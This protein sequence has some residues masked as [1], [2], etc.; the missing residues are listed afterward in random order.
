[1][2]YLKLTPDLLDGIIKTSVNDGLIED[3]KGVFSL[4]EQGQ[5][6]LE[7]ANELL[8]SRRREV[9]FFINEKT[10]LIISLLCLVFLSFL[11]ILMGL[12]SGSDALFNEGMENFTD[13]IKIFIIYLSMKFQ[14]DRL[15]SIIIMMFMLLTGILLMITSILSLIS[16]EIV[17]PD[18]YTFIIVSISIGLNYFLMHYKKIVGKLSANFSLLTDAKD[19]INNIRLST[20]VLIGLLFS[21]G[22]IYYIDSI[23]GTFISAIIIYDGVITL[24][25][26]ILAGEDIKIDA[27]KLKIDEKFD[28][29]ISYWILKTLHDKPLSKENLNDRF[30]QALDKG[31]KYYD[32]FAIIE[33]YDIQK[34]GIKKILE[35]MEREG[36]FIQKDHKIRLTNKGITQYYRARAIEF[37]EAAKEYENFGKEFLDRPIDTGTVS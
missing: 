3:K 10:I 16:N 25:E 23:I 15:G 1:M 5:D 33:F 35:E 34:T 9:K 18:L 8:L 27:F 12:N 22:N 19:N 26:L 24:R 4:T 7:K 11:K 36:L 2:S 31:Y 32:V 29:W 14:K 6:L 20:G 17:K 30:I 21:L 37:K 28:N 13:I